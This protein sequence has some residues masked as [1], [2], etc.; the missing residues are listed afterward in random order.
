[1]HF[2]TLNLFVEIF[3]LIIKRRHHN[4]L[5]IYVPSTNGELLTSFYIALSL[6]FAGS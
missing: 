6:L 2:S 1:M 3:S 4:K 5:L